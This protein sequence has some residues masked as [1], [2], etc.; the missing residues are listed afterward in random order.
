MSKTPFFVPLGVGVESDIADK[1]VQPGSTLETR[2]MYQRA[3]G[4]VATRFGGDVLATSGQATL[5]S[6]GTLPHVWQMG[7]LAGELVRFNQSPVPLHVLA[8]Q[9]AA[10]IRPSDNTIQSYRS[11]PISTSTNPVYASAVGGEAVASPTVAVSAN[12]MIT[13]YEYSSGALGGTAV[14]VVIQDIVTRTQVFTRQCA[15]GSKVP[16][17]LVIGSR[18]ICAYDNNG[19]LTVDAYDL[20]TLS[21]VQTQALGTCTPGTFISVRAGSNVSGRDMSI[22]FVYDAG[23]GNEVW[24]S[25]VASAALGTFTTYTVTAPGIGHATLA[26]LAL[27]W[28]QDFGA[29]GK[30]ALMVANTTDGLM[31]IWDVP[32]P[33]AGNANGAAT[34][35]LDAAAVA[36]PLTTT[37]GIRNVIGTTVS[38]SSTGLYRVFYEVTA[39]DYPT[40]AIVKQCVWTGS[41]QLGTGYRAIGIRSEIWADT[42]TYHFW[43]TFAGTE[44]RSY[45]VVAFPNDLTVD[46]VRSAPQAVAFPRAGGGLTERLSNPSQVATGPAGEHIAAVTMET[47]T[48]SVAPS[49]TA[50]GATSAIMAIELIAAK[51]R[52]AP[53]TELGK[54]VEFLG[55]LFTAGGMLGCFDGQT[56][57]HPLFAYYPP[58]MAIGLGSAGGNLEPSS[59]YSYRYLYARVDR[60]SKKWRSD[61]SAPETAATSGTNF[62]NTLDLETLR[63]VDAGTYQIEVYRTLADAPG[64]YFLVATIPNDPTT[65]TIQITDNV[66]DVDL[67]EELYTDGGGLPNQLL[68]PISH[69]IEHQGRLFCLEAGTSTVWYSTEADL[70]HGLIFNEELTNDVGNPADPGTGLAV[71]GQ[72][73]VVLKKNSVWAGGG[74]G[75]NALGQG[76]GYFFERRDSGVGC[77]NAA[78][79]VQVDDETWFLSNSQRAG[80]HKLN[81]ALDAEY[82]GGGVRRYMSGLTIAGA[83]AVPHLS[84]VRLFTVQG[85]TLVY[86]L[87]SKAWGT[88]TG[89]PAHAAIQGY[90]PVAGTVYAHATSFGL[91]S[92]STSSYVEA[93]TAY[94]GKLRSPWLSIASMRGWERIKRILG[95]GNPGGAHVVTVRLYADWDETTVI[96]TATKAFTGSETKW[97]WQVDPK[98]QKFSALMIEIEITG[99]PSMTSGPLVSGVTLLVETKRGLRKNPPGSRAT[100]S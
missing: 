49:S 34:H 3:Q 12:Y 64:A 99:N 71:V 31:V 55:S 1:L 15:T 44:Q 94:T 13:A 17:L 36:V 61:A 23:G 81:A 60:G 52:T 84:Q 51:H 7:T 46:T 27:G 45:F 59:N 29:S 2:N 38:A 76:D 87:I 100:N 92:E 95:V 50:T 43:A 4:E 79:I 62:K 86:D 26:D 28:L 18:V 37:A 53:E 97:D 40:R 56:Y 8:P 73:I 74:N 98:I 91:V 83:V 72:T 42:S 57:G 63:M 20:T 32:A 58:F 54:P 85:T 90:T 77:S 67:G 78:S 48:E 35:V 19:T 21:F 88:N 10:F 11:G 6:G 16:K 39:P 22:A 66:A 70:T 47:R 65:E 24:A 80:Y 82:V 89:Q 9:A 33:T 75:K 5:P 69:C 14:R 93:G 68:P 25:A 41:A 30:Y 96:G